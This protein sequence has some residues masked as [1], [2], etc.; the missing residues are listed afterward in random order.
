MT[1]RWLSLLPIAS[2]AACT[3]LGP[4]PATTGVS[5]IPADRPGVEVQ[6]GLVPVFFLSDAA[7]DGDSAYAASSQLSAL[8]TPRRDGLVLGARRWGEAGDAPVEPMIGWRRR[9]DDAFSIAGIGYGTFAYGEN[10]GASYEALRLG[11]ELAVD[12]RLVPI[13]RAL[14]IHVQASL[15]ATYLDASGTYCVGTTGQAVD[16]SSTSRRVDGEVHGIYTAATAGVALDIAR[17]PTGWLHH[18]RLAAVTALGGMP[19][20]RDGRQERSHDTFRS[21]GLSLSVGFGSDR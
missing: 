1:G 21:I 7:H 9:L 5:A 14:A 12:A 3:T 2:L 20:I 11:G 19:R 17:R 4:M 16:C 13:A 10:G 8:V 6:A 15:S 18:V